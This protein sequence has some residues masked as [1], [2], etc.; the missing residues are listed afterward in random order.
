MRIF[1]TIESIAAKTGGPA[2]SSQGLT[3]ALGRCGAEA[4]LLSFKKHEIPWFDGVVRHRTPDRD[5]Y[6]GYVNFIRGMI[7][8]FRPDVIQCNGIWQLHTHI[9]VQEA[10]RAKIPC[11]IAGRGNF[12]SWAM[13]KSYIKKKLAWYLYQRRDLKCAAGFHATSP[14]EADFIRELGFT[15]PVYVIPNGIEVPTDIVF[16]ECLRMR[17]EHRKNELRTR[18]VQFLARIHFQKGLRE[19][20]KAW[21]FIK[22]KNHGQNWVLEI[23]GPNP[24][25]HREQLIEQCRLDGLKCKVDREAFPFLSENDGPFVRERVDVLFPGEVSD[26]DKWSAYS[27]AD[28]SVLPSYTENFGLSIAE[29]LYMGLPVVATRDRTPWREIEDRQCGGWVKLEENAIAEELFRLM[30]LSDS[31][32]DDMG[33]RG[34]SLVAEKYTWDGVA[35]QMIDAYRDLI[36]MGSSRCQSSRKYD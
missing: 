14:A 28:I 12:S 6:S 18:R 10:K 35:P 8:E 22:M 13:Q 36:D 25:G 30:Q 11:L 7:A 1:N 20:L 26:S 4:W 32:R 15:Q 33:K 2:R 17:Q 9:I 16:R 34:H 24:V 19:L 27:R 29:A 21:A 3:A 5:G 23:I 31:D